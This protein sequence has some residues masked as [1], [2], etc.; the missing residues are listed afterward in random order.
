MGPVE[1]LVTL[2]QA[3]LGFLVAFMQLRKL[4]SCLYNKDI[5]GIKYGLGERY[6]V[7]HFFLLTSNSG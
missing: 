3:P 7:T 1:C 5:A 2:L 4:A 6:Q